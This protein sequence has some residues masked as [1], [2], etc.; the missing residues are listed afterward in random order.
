M[1]P[2][3]LLLLCQTLPRETLLNLFLSP[4]LL[5]PMFSSGAP[6]MAVISKRDVTVATVLD[7][8]ASFRD[9]LLEWRRTEVSDP[10]LNSARTVVRSLLLF[11][12]DLHLPPWHS[13]LRLRPWRF[14]FPTTICS[15]EGS[16]TMTDGRVLH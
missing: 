14:I 6:V 7:G 3:R 5:P 12:S 10:I 13:R 1:Q 9:H 11:S 15:S 8:E 4:L 2:P 16:S